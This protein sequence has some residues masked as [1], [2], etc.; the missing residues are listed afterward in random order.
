[1]G[2]VLRYPATTATALCLLVLTAF[3]WASG[4]LSPE[5]LPEYARSKRQIIGMALMLIAMP[6]YL[7]A[8]GFVAQRR[9][10]ELVEGLRPQLPE[11]RFADDA[12]A[13]IRGGL[14][15]SWRYGVAVGIVFGLL[16]S[17]PI[18]AIV[19]SRAPAIDISI[20]LGQMLL[21]LLAGLLLG[22][23]VTSARA[24]DRMG[25]VVRFEL[26]QIHELRPLARSGSLDV[27]MIAGALALSPLQA[28][29]AEFRW[30]NYRFAL[31]I[32]IP[33]ALVLLLWPLRSVHRRISVEKQGR[34]AQLEALIHAAR[35]RAT[36]E[37]VLQLETLL[38]HRD[39]LRDQKTWPLSTALISRVLLY[40][41]IPPLAWAGAA[42]VEKGVD[43]L[44]S[45]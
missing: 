7:L 42:L 26:F 41:V 33:A 43:W 2:G 40:L 31:L 20:A 12:L 15:R 16:N 30:Y 18:H 22:V 13:A 9:S 37:G 36:L 25:E 24:F 35:D 5:E 3:Y 17:Q 6:S 34:L 19:D 38:A 23:R 39:R 10:L 14:A 21:W 45:S 44:I 29:D 28:L 27:L 4:A 11:A 8:A 1:M 32:S